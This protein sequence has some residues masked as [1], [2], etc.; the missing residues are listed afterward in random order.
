MSFYFSFFMRTA[1]NS[2]GTQL[3]LIHWLSPVCSACPF[4]G[5]GSRLGTNIWDSFIWH[6]PSY[7]FAKWISEQV[8]SAQWRWCSERRLTFPQVAIYINTFKILFILNKVQSSVHKDFRLKASG[9]HVFKKI[10]PSISYNISMK[11]VCFSSMVFSA[12][13]FP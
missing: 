9:P 7:P 10:H 13:S 12:N 1:S 3:R 6:F 5:H 11:H 4:L 2:K 8:F